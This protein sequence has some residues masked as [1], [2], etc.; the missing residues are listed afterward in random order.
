MNHNSPLPPAG[1]L[2]AAGVDDDYVETHLQDGVA[3]LSMAGPNGNRLGPDLVAALAAAVTAALADG[4]VRALVITGRGA[5]FCAG[6]WTD[7]PPPG[8]DVPTIPPVLAQLAALCL[9]LENCPKPVVCALHGRV[10]S[11]GWALALAA[12]AR[13]CDARAQFSFPETRVGRL[14]P[15]NGTVRLAWQIGAAQAL[16]LLQAA[17]PLDAAGALALGLVDRVVDED[18]VPQAIARA[19]ALALAPLPPGDAARPGL[20]DAGGFRAAVTGA[21][22]VLR[23]PLPPHRR[24]EG[25]L[26]DAL[27]GAQL[28]PPDQALAFDLV[29]AQ[30]AAVEPAARALAHLARATR[31]ALDMPETRGAAAP[32]PVTPMAAALSPA[33]AAR[34]VPGAL[35][36]GRRVV[37]FD[38]QHDP[39]AETLEAV[40]A[41]QLDR[42]RSGRLTEAQS[43]ADWQ[44]LS[45]RMTP[46]P[47]Q[48]PTLAL[49]DAE[50]APWL[51]GLFPPTVP[52]VLW[53]PRG[54]GLPAG[55]TP[56]RCIELVPAPGSTPRVCE[57]VVHDATAPETVRHAAALAMALRITPLRAG[58]APWIA[59]VAQAVTHAAT[60]LRA[61][62]IDTATLTATGLVPAALAEGPVADTAQPLPL[63]ADRLLLLAAINA[64]ARLLESGAALRPSDIDL[65]LVL[66]AGWPSWR[67]GPM[68]EG[69]TI[70]ALVLRHELRRASALAP[71]LWTPEPMLDEMIRN[72]WRFDDLNTG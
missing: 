55:L 31:R 3:L 11:G 29:R 64:G 70:G 44:R 16:A 28:L 48:P 40:A 69:D 59:R 72:G 43:E 33:L 22:A 52:L 18:L 46:D 20:H 53:S 27:E 42:V 2:A 57:L 5:D 6:A 39:L 9:T 15:G 62:G 8:P 71:D 58:G 7:L 23:A 65:G 45:G 56:A 21:R 66:G 38:P 19:E 36:G 12:R 35:H 50:H 1:P 68:A 4:G 49:S 13:L 63:P 67:G 30:D 54:Q 25:L 41:A 60:R 14:P 61:L 34:L 51:A 32:P 10:A 24:A 37:L 17:A 26:V 47:E